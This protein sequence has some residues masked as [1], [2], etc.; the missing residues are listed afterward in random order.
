MP[1]GVPNI[2]FRKTSA[3]SQ[4]TG[5]PKVDY[6]VPLQK[7]PVS[8]VLTPKQAPEVSNETD[9]EIL[10]R[11]NN[12][13]EVLSEMVD[14]AIIGEAKAIVVSGPAGVGKSFLV[15]EKLEAHDPN[16]INYTVIK[17]TVRATGLFSTLYD[18]REAG[19]IVVFDDA[20]SIF[21]DEQC[22]NFLKATCDTSKKRIV[23]YLSQVDLV[24]EKT[25]ESIPKT[26]EFEGTIIFIS[27]Y[28]FDGLI[29]AKNKLSPHLQ[30][31][32][33]RSYY[34]DLSMKTTRD[35]FLR[36]KD[37]VDKGMLAGLTDEQKEDVLN[38]ISEYR[39]QMR[40]L[41]LRSAIKIAGLRKTKKNWKMIAEKTCCRQL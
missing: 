24:S 15:E 34:I 18:H 3:W 40:E 6:S 32:M 21:S 29:E 26:F 23:S 2:G 37:I 14:E 11:I 31:L 28:D 33:S 12:S 8:L 7:A 1:R 17:G 19:Q 41:S 13:F 38:F 16:G 5:L 20:D 36:I 25:G 27:N 10:E 22:L 39:D 4:R 35:C 30:A 9:A